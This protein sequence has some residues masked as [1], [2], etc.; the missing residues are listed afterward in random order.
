MNLY[1]CV[2]VYSQL[3]EFRE[4]TF[5]NFNN[6]KKHIQFIQEVKEVI[7][8]IRDCTYNQ[9]AMQLSGGGSSCELHFVRKSNLI[10]VLGS[11]VCVI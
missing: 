5:G 8:F 1:G 11:F 4:K 7:K 2:C 6:T 9:R 10:N 3:N